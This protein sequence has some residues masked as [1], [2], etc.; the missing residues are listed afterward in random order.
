MHLICEPSILYF[1]TPVAIISSHNENGTTNLAPISSI[2]WLG[3]RC[4]IG[5]GSGN[6]TTENLHRNK[7][8]VI[9]LPSIDQVAGVDRLALKTGSNPVPV[10]K[11]KRGYYYEPDKFGISGFT[12]EPSAGPYPS[13]VKECP[14]QMEATVVAAH[15][16]AQDDPAITGRITSFELKIDR[17]YLEEHLL[18]TGQTDRVDPDK[19]KPLIMSFQH[20]YGV[21]QQIHPSTLAQIPERLY[22]T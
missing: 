22:R 11:E 1:G 16:L 6:K 5:L 7:H 21:G 12:A 9:N 17:V 4:I 2:F 10:T 15:R 3:W 19:W 8:C 14:V 13:R 20:F 18:M